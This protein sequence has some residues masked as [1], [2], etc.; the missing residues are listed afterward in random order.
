MNAIV[1][2]GAGRTIE[3]GAQARVEYRF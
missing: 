3:A 1:V 2:G